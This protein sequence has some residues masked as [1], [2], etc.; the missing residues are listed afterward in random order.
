MSPTRQVAQASGGRRAEDDQVPV[1]LLALAAGGH[2]VLL[3]QL[4]LEPADVGVLGGEV[5]L[6]PELPGPFDPLPRL[7]ER[8][9]SGFGRGDAVDAGERALD[10]GDGVA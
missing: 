4:M 5:P 8:G 6:T 9:L 2:L 1:R 10:L 3:D 7:L